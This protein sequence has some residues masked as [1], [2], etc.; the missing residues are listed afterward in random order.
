MAM[1][2]LLMGAAPLASVL[3]WRDNPDIR[4]EWL[5]SPI[6]GVFELTR[7]RVHTSLAPDITAL[8]WGIIA[9]PAVMGVVFWSIAAARDARIAGRLAMGPGGRA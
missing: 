1:L 3:T 8:H 5:L 4:T 6:S 9:L 7:N 2:I